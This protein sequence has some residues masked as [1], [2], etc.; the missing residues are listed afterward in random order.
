MAARE[1]PGFR[2][3]ARS[4]PSPTFLERGVHDVV[5][6]ESTGSQDDRVSVP[7]PENAPWRMVCAL[8]ITGQVGGRVPGTGWLAGPRTVITAGHCVFDEATLEGLAQSIMVTPGLSGGTRPFGAVTATRFRTLPEWRASADPDF[9][10]GAI[11]LDESLGSRVGFFTAAALTGA[12]LEKRLAHLSGY[13][14]FPGNGLQ[15]FHHRNRILAATDR[16]LFYATDSSQGQSGAPVWVLESDGG[17]PRVVGVHTYGFERTP[18]GM[19]ESNS[20]TLIN[21]AIL[22]QI[23]AWVEEDGA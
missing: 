11:S 5:A 14:E 18:P 6:L 12:E 13:P 19:P 17:T 20:G 16:R 3:T 7:D 2:G 23:A 9:D 22:D 8:T 1:R 15:Q 4:A 21:G 10:L